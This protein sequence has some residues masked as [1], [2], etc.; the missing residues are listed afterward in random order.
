MTNKE[1]EQQLE[2]T[3]VDKRIQAAR[4]LAEHDARPE[5]FHLLM[6]HIPDADDR[7]RFWALSAC[8]WKYQAQ[9]LAHAEQ[10]APVLMARLVDDYSPVIDRATWALNIV[11]ETVFPQL[12]AATSSPDARTR[13]LA[14][15]LGQ[16]HQ[17]HK[18]PQQGLSALFQLLDDPEEQV[19][20]SAMHAIMGLTPLRLTPQ[21]TLK[22][23][24]FEPIYFRLLPLIEKFSRHEDANL[25]EW[26]IRYKE[27]ILNR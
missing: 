5:L 4:F 23:V 26:G 2:S 7:V 8:V 14:A 10:L 24:D 19:Q 16:N 13:L 18:A 6:S 22:E 20:S 11:G 15:A 12:I 25:R 3:D 21:G 1:I 17:M 9:L 27:L